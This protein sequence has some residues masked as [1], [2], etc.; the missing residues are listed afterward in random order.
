MSDGQLSDACD[1]AARRRT[2]RTAP[3]APNDWFNELNISPWGT[4]IDASTAA[5]MP[6]TATHTRVVRERPFAP[7]RCRTQRPRHRAAFAVAQDGE[8]SIRGLTQDEIWRA[9]ALG[10]PAPSS[11]TT[12]CLRK[13]TPTDTIG[14]VRTGRVLSRARK[15]R[16]MFRRVPAQQPLRCVARRPNR[17]TDGSVSSPTH[18]LLI[19]V[20]FSF[21]G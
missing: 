11:R 9:P 21:R 4:R 3:L 15:G 12:A 10:S 14:Q 16:R 5:S 1:A 7:R 13:S 17:T 20:F 19:P 18:V 2:P 8:L 6:A